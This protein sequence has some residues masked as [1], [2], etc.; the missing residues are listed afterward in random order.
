MFD[1]SPISRTIA[2][3]LLS[4][5]AGAAQADN[6]FYVGGGGGQSFVDEGA[7]D[8]EDTAFSLF[9]GY[10][11]NRYFAVEGGYADFGEIEPN[12][13]TALEADTFHL[14]AVGTF[15]VNDVFSLYAKAGAHRWDADTS[16]SILGGDDTG[17][18][19]TYGIGGQYRFND[20]FALRAEVSRFE[21]EDTDV[22]VAQ[23][24]A[25]FDF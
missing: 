14:T 6:G 3:L 16:L 13:G 21:L 17:T 23:L 19:P 12:A 9:G 15:P 4:A 7:Y 8:D 25:R 20:R 24:Q 22:D 10:E 5:V 18:D 1:K 11:L 2:L